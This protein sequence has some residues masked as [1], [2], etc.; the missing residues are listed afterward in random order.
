MNGRRGDRGARSDHRRLLCEG[1][2]D[3][4]GVLAAAGFAALW[5]GR[6]VLPSELLPGADS[7]ELA[8]SLARVGRAE[9]DDAGRLV[10]IHGLTLRRTRHRFTHRA[11]ARHT[12]CAFDAVGIPAALGLDA[13]AS[14]NCPTCE[15]PVVVT[16]RCGTP[17]GSDAA[18]W[19]PE[20]PR[21]DL[22]AEF[23]STADL[24]CTAEHLSGR[25]SPGTVP[26]RVVDVAL[27]AE[28]GRDVW[29]DVAQ[30]QV[31]T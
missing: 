5:A 17:L 30:L 26:G 27:A 7:A 28:I 13:T 3:R 25:I 29:S 8:E 21:A 9:L 16:L 15:A 24:Y 4:S 1:A 12:W 22:L 23:C 6:A 31:P 20:P 2:G 11:R 18:L 14:T 10:G 19:F